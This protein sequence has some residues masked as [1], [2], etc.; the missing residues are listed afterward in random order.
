MPAVSVE[1]V[2]EADPEAIVTT[3][4]DASAANGDGLE[5]WRK[6]PRLRATAWHNLIVLDADTIHRASPRILDGAAALCEQLEAV[7]TRRPP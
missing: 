1:A 5:L 4:T 6:F 2:I 3:G 7:R